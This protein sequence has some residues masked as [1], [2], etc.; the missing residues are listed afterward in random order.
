MR[1]AAVTGTILLCLALV[2]P[3]GCGRKGGS[4]LDAAIVHAGKITP[5]NQLDE[6]LRDA[7][8]DLTNHLMTQD[9]R[10]ARRWS[11]ALDF[12]ELGVTHTAGGDSDQDF[13]CGR[14]GISQLCKL[15]RR[16][17]LREIAELL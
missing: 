14:R 9:N 8:L 13:T 17:R 15:E 12:V 11:T 1:T 5:L 16:G 2:L 6:R 3:S 7:C 10:Q 4:G